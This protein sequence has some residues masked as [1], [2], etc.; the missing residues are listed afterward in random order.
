MREMV[1]PEKESRRAGERSR[2][3]SDTMLRRWASVLR[4][5]HE[6]GQVGRPHPGP[7]R[8]MK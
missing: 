7:A 4:M 6:Q 3:S 1:D 8:T 2:R 5:D